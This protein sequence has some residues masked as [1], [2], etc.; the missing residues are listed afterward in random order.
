[1]GFNYKPDICIVG[2]GPAG[3][4]AALTLS[5]S[6]LAQNILCIDMGNDNKIRSCS[7]L[8]GGKCEEEI[9]CQMIS[10][11]GGCS[12]L[13]GGKIG[14]FPAG[15]E[16]EV[17]LG[18]K[19]LARKKLLEAFA[20]I[21]TYI[22]LN[23]PNITVDET[24][25]ANRDFKTLGFD[26]KYYDSYLFSPKELQRAYKDIILELESKGL[27]LSMKTQLR[28][29]ES[30]DDGFKL[31]VIKDGNCVTISTKYLILGMGRSG[32]DFLKQINSELNL[33]G[34]YNY[35]DVG[36]RLE[37]PT[38]LWQ[39]MSKYHNDLKLV[40]KD[41]RTFCVCKDGK[42]APYCLHDVLFTEGY[43]DTE[44][45]SGLTNLGI[46]VRLAPSEQNETILDEIKNTELLISNGLPIG[47]KLTDYL[48]IKS[49]K[50]NKEYLIKS[51]MACWVRGNIDQLYP[52]FVS[53]KI[54]DAV[55]YFTSRLMPEN[56]LESMYVF[57]P[58]IDYGGLSF[59]INADFSINPGMYLIGE[60]TGKF[61][62]I[63]PAFCS[64][65]VC[66]EGIIGDLNEI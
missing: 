57:A 30:K 23:K 35:L 24:E 45:Q 63:L 33:G 7:I 22:P 2:L 66:A 14:V 19:D 26:Y 39:D 41:A 55:V 65:I 32:R 17:I 44:C 46:L 28:G 1:M 12:S 11:F 31:Q 56:C 21:N 8:N 9:P 13:S 60:C 6:D 16:L 27:Q 47:Q 64:G 34:K 54:R 10:G 58:E 20:L 4:G 52:P 48:N 36:V 42:V 53:Q 61:R 38:H 50:E 40:F 62:G 15:S 51:S 3:I 59:P 18:T 25:S 37:F 5:K 49:D 43:C 29:I